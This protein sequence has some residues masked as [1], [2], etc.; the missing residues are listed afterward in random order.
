MSRSISLQ[1]AK[2]PKS[3]VSFR[4]DN[5]APVS[6]TSDDDTFPSF[7]PAV[8]SIR[9]LDGTSS[10]VPLFLLSCPYVEREQVHIILIRTLL[11][12]T[13]ANNWQTTNI[14]GGAGRQASTP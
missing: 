12:C 7:L 3:F 13:T 8:L 2:L 6:G 1:A 10:F 9:D 11:L 14:A 4:T 5:N